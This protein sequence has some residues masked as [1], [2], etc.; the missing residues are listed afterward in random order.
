MGAP[1]LPN[2]FARRTWGRKPTS[3]RRLASYGQ[4]HGERVPGDLSRK[5]TVENFD[6]GVRNRAVGMIQAGMSQRD[7]ALGLGH[8][9][10]PSNAG[11]KNAN[12][13]TEPASNKSGSATHP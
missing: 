12:R 2:T 8:P 3:D 4:N 13:Q 5:M 10:V 11:G 1:L 7:V 9:S 6:L